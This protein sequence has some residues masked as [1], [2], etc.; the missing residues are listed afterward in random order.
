MDSRAITRRLA[1]L[2]KIADRNR[3]CRI[4]VT[5][6]DGSSTTT[7]PTGAIDVFRERGPSGDISCFSADRP[8]Y[9]G[10]CGALSVL[11]HPAPNR[12][13]TDFE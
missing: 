10:L 13:V 8:E 3:P 5:F 2:Q 12:E 7:D 4:V 1:A 9:V 11:C 6:A